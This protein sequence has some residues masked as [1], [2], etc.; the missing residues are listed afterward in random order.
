MTWG[1]RL[2][3]V[4]LGT[5]SILAPLAVV[6]AG[7]L[8]AR[9]LISGRE[10]PVRVERE[11]RAT[12][13]EVVPIRAE[14]HRPTIRQRGTVRAYRQVSVQA[15]V[16]GRVVA[17]SEGLLPGGILSKGDLLVRIDPR[18]YETI[19]Q[20]EKANLARAQFDLKVEE[21]RQVVAAREWGLLKESIETNALS[22]ELALRK[23][24]LAEK[25][26]AVEAAQSRVRKAKID[27]ERTELRA[28]FNAVVLEE[29]VEIGQLVNPQAMVA[30]L[31]CIDEFHIEVSLRLDQL[32]WVS[33]PG[34][35]S[36]GGSPV[37]VI[38]GVDQEHGVVRE[39]EVVLL[40]GDVEMGRMARLLVSVRDP[41][42]VLAGK[43]LAAPLLVGELVEVEIDGPEIENLVAVPRQ[44]E[45]EPGR[46]WVK[47]GADLLAV[48]EV[49]RVFGTDGDI[50]VRNSFE[51]GDQLITSAPPV[52]IPGMRLT[53][54]ETERQRAA[55]Y[56][57]TKVEGGPSKRSS[58]TSPQMSVEPATAVDGVANR[59][60]DEA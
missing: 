2:A 15:Q 5:L 53:T 60:D 43:H 24:H 39:G 3:R 44:A 7:A 42:G 29:A 35:G 47:T 55:P 21:G 50:L 41:L 28:P 10:L 19:V 58:G 48:R 11:A 51:P 18:D 56:G 13:V 34:R 52:A 27:L 20:Q 49:E 6:V 36:D 25:K 33:V 14:T 57:D 45:R 37:R 22:Q 17:Q 26:A 8:G 9:W 46:V 54:E 1:R 59:D 16:G 31:V 4:T 30:R 40:L 32:A 23:P 12:F 38:L